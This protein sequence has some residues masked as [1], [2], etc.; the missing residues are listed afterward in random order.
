M[1]LGH[2]NELNGGFGVVAQLRAS[3]VLSN[4]QSASEREK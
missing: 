3:N 1:I 4:Y 2:L